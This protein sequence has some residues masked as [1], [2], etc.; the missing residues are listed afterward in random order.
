MFLDV[1]DV[2]LEISVI[3]TDVNLNGECAR[4]KKENGKSVSALVLIDWP[5]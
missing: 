3:S 5:Q 1:W 2:R 4:E